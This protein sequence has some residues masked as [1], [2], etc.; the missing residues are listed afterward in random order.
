MMCDAQRRDGQR[1]KANAL[2]GA[3]RCSLHA[4][5][6]RA[7]ELARRK[8]R[9]TP[10]VDLPKFPRP[11]TAIDLQLILASTL[12]EIR[13]GLLEAKLGNAIAGVATAFLAALKA[14]ELERRVG[15]LEQQFRARLKGTHGR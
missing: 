6:H 12:T 7:A 8:Q 14:G 3:T 5:P 11:R 4:T 10:K 1:C 2:R 13:A 15:A 9:A